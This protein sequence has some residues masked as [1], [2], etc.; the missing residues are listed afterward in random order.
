MLWPS[1]LRG[2]P[3]S[4]S[5]RGFAGPKMLVAAI[6]LTSV[7]PRMVV[8]PDGLVMFYLLRKTFASFISPKVRLV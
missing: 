4:L 6:L 3:S 1:L 5:L 2:D 8:E 7:A